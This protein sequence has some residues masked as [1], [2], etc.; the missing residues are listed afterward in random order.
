MFVER[1]VRKGWDRHSEACIF[2]ACES[3]ETCNDVLNSSNDECCNELNDTRISE[4]NRNRFEGEHPVASGSYS[5]VSDKSSKL[6]ECLG[7]ESLLDKVQLSDLEDSTSDRGVD[8]ERSNSTVTCGQEIESP[9]VSMAVVTCCRGV[10]SSSTRDILTEGHHYET[11]DPWSRSTVKHLTPGNVALTPT[12]LKR[13]K[14]RNNSEINTSEKPAKKLEP[15]QAMKDNNSTNL[16]VNTIESSNV[17]VHVKG[18]SSCDLM[19]SCTE[20]GRSLK[21]FEDSEPECL[22]QNIDKVIISGRVKHG[23]TNGG[24][25]YNRNP[26]KGS[27]LPESDKQPADMGKHSESDLESDK[28]V[29]KVVKSVTS[30]SGIPVYHYRRHLTEGHQTSVS[31]RHSLVPQHLTQDRNNSSISCSVGSSSSLSCSRI[32]KT[33][34]IGAD[35]QT[36]DTATIVARKE[37]CSCAPTAS[38]VS[39]RSDVSIE[40]QN[41]TVKK[42]QFASSRNNTTA[43]SQRAFQLN[44]TSQLVHETKTSKL[45]QKKFSGEQT[46]D[47]SLES[48]RDTAS[49]VC[50]VKRSLPSTPAEVR[51]VKFGHCVSLK[52]TQQSIRTGSAETG[53]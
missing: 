45:R 32:N 28:G 18:R 4:F 42:R 16:V 50:T 2:I 8:S 29:I 22:Q 40:S 39:T 25:T 14:H 10:V 38:P 31:S 51:T 23:D 24:N 13:A 1:S 9:P 35:S 33:W 36:Q 17:Q 6:S 34:D 27:L 12:P 44:N 43:T 3:I 11:I 30:V 26:F 53:K 20:S 49:S 15:K 7:R 47:V 21:D 46:Y 37:T 52:K 19:K 48:D 5:L 41:Q